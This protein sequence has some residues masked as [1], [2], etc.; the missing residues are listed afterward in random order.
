MVK[1]R[2]AGESMQKVRS[3]AL[4]VIEAVDKVSG[5]LAEQS[6]ASMQI[7]AAVDRIAAMSR[8]DSQAVGVI[9]GSAQAVQ[10]LAA[11]LSALATRFQPRA[12]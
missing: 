3:G 8:E 11:S 6:A 10:S 2:G 12:V 7:A 4:E 9:S 5:A 1:A